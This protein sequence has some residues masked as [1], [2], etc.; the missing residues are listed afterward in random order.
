[1]PVTAGLKILSQIIDNQ[2]VYYPQCNKNENDTQ[3]S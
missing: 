1:M 2:Q 3:T